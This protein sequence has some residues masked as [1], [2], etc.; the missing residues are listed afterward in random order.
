[1][2]ALRDPLDL[3]RQLISLPSVTPDDKGCQRLIADRLVPLDFRIET[4]EVGGVTNL[5]ARRGTAAPLFCF[6]GHTDVVPP[7][8]RHMWRS[9]PFVPSLREGKL[10]GRGAADMKSSIA[11]FIT[12]AESFI[13][14]APGH[15]GSIGVLLT[16][17]EE[18]PAVDG[19]IRFVERLRDRGE[20]ID[21]CLVGE[22]TCTSVLGDAVKN[23]RRGSLSGRLVVKGVQGH[24]AYAHL[25]RNPVHALAPALAE[26]A[27]AEWDRGNEDFP[28]TT[29]QV[30][31]I[32][33]GEGVGNV[34]P[35]ECEVQ[36]NFRFSTAAAPEA[37]KDRLRQVL[38]RHGL[39]YSLHWT[40]SAVPY[41]TRRGKLIGALLDAI[42]EVTGVDAEL[43]TAG[44]TSDGRYI[45]AI[46]DEVAEFGPVNLTIH[47]VNEYIAEADVAPLARIY[48]SLLERLLSP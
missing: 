31:N 43:S 45:A 16:S 13:G 20:R 41:L 15:A 38:D 10:F 18:G 14:A 17:D 29:W 3:A 1:M 34:I 37:L 12:A 47:K 22:P 46:C 6:A 2:S 8:P 19:T 21:F 40:L 27:A 30:S 32:H 26:L 35:G 48:R 4:L 7:G 42:R 28:P 33:A 39:E 5:F 36:F 24:I 44:G 25:A 9:D 23:G 11:A